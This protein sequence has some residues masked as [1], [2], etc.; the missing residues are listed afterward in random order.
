MSFTLCTSG[1][2]VAKAGA[3]V[4]STAK[5]SGALLQQ[6]CDEAEGFINASTRID[7]IGQYASVPVNFKP[8]LA[9][10]ASSIAAIPLISWNMS[11]YTNRGE[12]E[13]MINI[14]H[15]KAARALAVLSEDNVKTVMG[16]SS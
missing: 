8:I 1:A 4:N 7:W 3:N 2:I 14:N 15:D 16:V 6:F 10:A 12:A 5:A 13:D 11:G 9:D